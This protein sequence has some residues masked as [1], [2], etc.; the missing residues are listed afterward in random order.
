[1][2]MVKLDRTKAALLVI[3]VQ[4]RLAAAMNAESFERLLNRT[5]AAVEGA[6]ALGLP[7][8]YTEQYPKGLGPTLPSLREALGELPRVEKITFSGDLPEVAAAL[9][10]RTQILVT[11][12]ETHVCVFQTVRDLSARGLKPFLLADAV[13]SRTAV[14]RQ[15]GLD[16][17]RD[18]GAV[19]TST[20]AALFDLCGQAGTPEFKKISAAVK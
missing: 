18:A 13:L 19:I 6:K 17:C 9:G 16:L 4:E 3:D 10:D 8:V 14:D 7:I 12:M 20:E 5:R 15:I 11:G 2:T 1:M